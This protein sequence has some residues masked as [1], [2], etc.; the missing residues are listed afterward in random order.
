MRPP[1]FFRNIQKRI[2]EIE[3]RIA[4]TVVVVEAK[5]MW[6]KNFRTESFTDK[7]PIPWKPRKVNPKDKDTKKR[8]LLVGP[9][10]NAGLLRRQATNG[11]VSGNRV[12]FNVAVAYG[13][14]H[15]EGLRAGRGKGFTMPK[16]QFIGDSA[17]LNER[18]ERKTKAFITQFLNRT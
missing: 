7:A 17:V 15:N 10:R 2:S 12:T 18:I 6:I 1:D 14:V 8:M 11:V 9:T 16:R 13:K 4:S 3:N 5:T